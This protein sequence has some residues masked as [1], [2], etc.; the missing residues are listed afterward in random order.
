MEADLDTDLSSNKAKLALFN[1]SSGSCVRTTGYIHDTINYIYI[2]SSDSSNNK[3]STDTSDQFVSSCTSE[4]SGKIDK[5][6][7]NVYC[8]GDT[9]SIN[10]SSPNGYYMVYNGSNGHNLVLKVD[11]I[12]SEVGAIT[13]K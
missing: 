3:A 2:A 6:N 9:S 12:I 11:G 4:N 13:G 10:F 8:I 5:A 1:C 7:S